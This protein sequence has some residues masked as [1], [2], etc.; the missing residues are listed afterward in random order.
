MPVS[1]RRQMKR[2][3]HQDRWLDTVALAAALLLAGPVHVEKQWLHIDGQ[4][5]LEFDCEQDPSEDNFPGMLFEQDY[6]GAGVHPVRPRPPGHGI[7]AR[8]NRYSQL[9]EIVL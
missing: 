2:K 3:S 6:S 1:A 4:Q 9:Q 7:P 8:K 5:P